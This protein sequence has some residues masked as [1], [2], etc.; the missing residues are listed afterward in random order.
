M[1]THIQNNLDML[2]TTSTNK[3]DEL[4]LI[5]N[6]SGHGAQKNCQEWKKVSKMFSNV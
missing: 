6:S 3:W 4:T 1:V 5:S 2:D